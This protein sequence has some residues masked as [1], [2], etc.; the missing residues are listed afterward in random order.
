[1]DNKIP[2]INT[3]DTLLITVKLLLVADISISSGVVK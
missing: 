1:M 2:D 3:F